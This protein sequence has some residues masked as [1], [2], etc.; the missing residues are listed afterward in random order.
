MTMTEPARTEAWSAEAGDE[1]RARQADDRERCAQCGA[2]LDEDQEWCL[3]CGSSRTL[4]Y[5]APDWRIPVGIV[6]VVIV[7][8]IGGFAFALSRLSGTTAAAP[9]SAGRVSIASSGLHAAAVSS[10]VPA[11]G[12]S[13]RSG[14]AGR[15]PAIASWP[16][17]LSGWTVV[18]ARYTSESAAYARA[19]VVAPTGT[20]VGVFDSSE[21]PAMTPGYWVVFSG[22]FPNRLEARAGAAHLV[23]EGYTT[24]VAREVSPPGGL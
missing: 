24:A 15:I 14:L 17:G 2:P 16:V 4:I 23:A 12:T 19:K 9:A 22:R 1:R 20:P 7:L 10:L 13:G 21:H 11:A 18:L 8:A 6:L 5:T 3:E